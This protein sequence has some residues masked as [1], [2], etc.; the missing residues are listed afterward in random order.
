[1]RIGTLDLEQFYPETNLQTVTAATLLTMPTL[2]TGNFVAGASALG[3][4]WVA[5]Q[6]LTAW[7]RDNCLLGSDL[8]VIDTRDHA[9]AN[10]NDAVTARLRKATGNH[11]LTAI[12]SRSAQYRLLMVA[13]DDPAQIAKV[14]PRVASVLGVAPDALGWIPTAGRDLSIILAPLERA[15]WLPVAFDESAL[16]PG[17]LIGYIG[18]DVL[19]NHVTYSR[20]DAPHMLISGTTRS[21]KTEAIRADIQSMRL[22]GLK[23]EIHIIDAKGTLCREQCATFTADMREGLATL[24]AIVEQAR[25]RIKEI[26]AVG[27][28][29]WFQYKAKCPDVCP[30]PIMVYVDEYPQLRALDK[31][32]V[33][34]V[35]GE[36]SR[37]HAA[38][39]VFVTLGIQKPKAET[40]P[41]EIRDMFDIR[42]AMRVP[43]SKA[44]G[45]AIDEPGAE[46]LPGAGAFMFRNGGDSVVR[47]RGAFIEI[48]I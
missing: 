43:D 32:T 5:R 48:S 28:D 8:D 1:M 27:C 16:T 15:E 17:K 42:L 12:E 44:S 2:V 18:R 38:S 23:P 4:A 47:G 36:L 7:R 33:E 13:N 30:A 3:L 6:A 46:G 37:V 10:T 14:L 29:N 24:Q 35:V 21:G 26:V 22:S 31:E 19:S 39:G 20:Q 9:A 41:T 34:A 45:V 40:L 11:D 25:E